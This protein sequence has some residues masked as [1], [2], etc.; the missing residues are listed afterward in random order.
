MDSKMTKSSKPT[1]KSELD[2]IIEFELFHQPGPPPAP[3][4][5]KPECDGWSDIINKLRDLQVDRWD[6]RYSDPF[7]MDG[8]SWSLIVRSAGLKIK[9][10]GL[11]AYPPNFDAVN[12]FIENSVAIAPEPDDKLGFSCV[13]KPRKC[14]SCGST[15]VASIHYGMPASSEELFEKERLGKVIFGGCVIAIDGSQ[16]NWQCPKC[17]AQFF[18]KAVPDFPA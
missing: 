3:V 4:I 10:S 7:I 9:S 15:T 5:I 1:R 18:K 16:P 12:E 6:A 13:R 8:S 17:D 11:N 2:N 14:P